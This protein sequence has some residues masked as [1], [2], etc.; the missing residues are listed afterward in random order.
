[1]IENEFVLVDANN[2]SI[3]LKFE[4]MTTRHVTATDMRKKSL[5]VSLFQQ[6]TTLY[7]S[8]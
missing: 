6:N 5:D 1:M 2:I 4:I 7:N 3:G 8:S